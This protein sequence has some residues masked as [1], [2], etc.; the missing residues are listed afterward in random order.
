MDKIWYRNPSKSEVN[1]HCGGDEK[2]EWPSRTDKSGTLKNKFK[3]S[4]PTVFNS[5]KWKLLHMILIM[6]RCVWHSLWGP[7]KGFQYDS[8]LK[9][10]YI[11]ISLFPETKWAR[12]V[13]FSQSVIALVW[14]NAF[15]HVLQIWKCFCFYF[16]LVVKDIPIV[17]L[18]QGHVYILLFV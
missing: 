9:F 4:T 7:T 2:T 3:K 17:S 18:S 1:G 16:L 6:C 8:F 10:F 5:A 14:F 13:Y 15:W 11:H 12:M